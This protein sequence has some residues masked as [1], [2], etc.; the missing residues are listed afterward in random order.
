MQDTDENVKGVFKCFEILI[1]EKQ[2]SQSEKPNSWNPGDQLEVHLQN[3]VWV[4]PLAN[5]KHLCHL[6]AQ[7]Q[8]TGLASTTVSELWPQNGALVLSSPPLWNTFSSRS[9]KSKSGMKP[10]H[11]ITTSVSFLPSTNESILCGFTGS[12][13]R[14]YPPQH[15]QKLPA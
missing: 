6:E 15:L 10:F 4:R 8:V 13:V 5:G 14:I 3:Y 9:T 1:E 7:W 11:R 12:F 2:K